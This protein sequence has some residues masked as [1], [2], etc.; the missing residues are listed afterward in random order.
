MSILLELDTKYQ[1]RGSV[2]FIPYKD[3]KTVEFFKSNIR[4][5]KKLY[6]EKHLINFISSLDG[7]STVGELINRLNLNKQ[8]IFALIDF[9]KKHCLIQSI[10]TSVFI[11]QHQFAHV[12]NFLADYIP[13]QELENYFNKI[14]NFHIVIIGLGAVGSWT[15]IQLAKTGLKKFTLIDDD[16]VEQSNLNRTFFTL[17]DIGE[18]KVDSMKKHL[19]KISTEI[20]CT[21]IESHISSQNALKNILGNVENNNLLVI[22]CADMPNVDTTS[23][24]VNKVC[25]ELNI[26]Y[27]IAGGYNLHLTLLGPTIIPYE[28]ACYKCIDF[29][30]NYNDTI[31][32]ILKSKKLVRPNRNIGNI[33]PMATIT[34]SFVVNETIRTIL[35]SKFLKPVMLNKRGNINFFTNNITFQDFFRDATCKECAT[36]ENSIIIDKNIFI[37][38]FNRQCKIITASHKS[39][40]T[41][42]DL[43]NFF[44]LIDYKLS[45]FNKIDFSQLSISNSE[46]NTLKYLLA[47]TFDKYNS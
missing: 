42:I 47:K 9:L 18:K 45:N 1:L 20:K 10:Q 35:K 23:S 13:Y 33:V 17:Q 14:Q 6:L 32:E 37:Q 2:S 21:T 29:Q 3:G 16:T 43:L 24:W 38:E 30:L 26:P 31:D 15:T 11:E 44:N 39:F 12:L 46:I 5:S 27:I 34:S 40:I 28:T 8:A 4:I 36:E 7:S 41:K 25:L 22:N 19:Y